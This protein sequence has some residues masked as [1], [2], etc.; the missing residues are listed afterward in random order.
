MINLKKKKEEV[1]VEID[2]NFIKEIESVA[3]TEINIEQVVLSNMP[4]TK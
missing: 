1:V 2:K 4:C 3:Y